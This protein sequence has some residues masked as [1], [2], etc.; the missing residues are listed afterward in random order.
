MTY[1]TINDK[2][3]FTIS[4]KTPVFFPL[5]E[6]LMFLTSFAKIGRNIVAVAVLLVTS[7]KIAVIVTRS[8]TMIQGWKSAK[9]PNA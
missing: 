1:N 5:E 6:V 7:V 4:Y 8:K 3:R 9:F 2:H